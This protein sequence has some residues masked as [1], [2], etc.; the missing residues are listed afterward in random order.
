MRRTLAT[1]TLLGLAIGLSLT[2]CTESQVEDVVDVL[3]D[4]IQVPMRWCAV[5]GSP[6][7]SGRSPGEL[8]SADGI[9]DSMRDTNLSITLP[10]ALVLLVP[11]D[12]PNGIPVVPDPNTEGHGLGDIAVAGLSAELTEVWGSCEQAWANLY[13]EQ[14]GIVAVNANVIIGAGVDTGGAAPSVPKALWVASPIQFTGQR[15]DDL[16]GSPRNITPADVLPMLKVIVYDPELF[17]SAY[18]KESLHPEKVLA[19]EVGHALMLPHG[20]GL[21]DDGDGLLPPDPGER[22]F[23]EYCDAQGENE[24]QPFVSCEETGSLM[25]GNQCRAIRPLQDE[26]LRAVAKLVPGSVFFEEQGPSAGSMV[27]STDPCFADCPLPADLT[28]FKFELT[29]ATDGVHQYLTTVMGPFSASED[30]QYITYLDSDA[31]QLTGCDPQAI[32]LPEF[33]GAD[34]AI[35]VEVSAETQRPAAR[36]WTCRESSFEPINDRRMS[37]SAYTTSA[38]VEGGI[39]TLPMSGTIAVNF[40]STLL[41]RGTDPRVQVFSNRPNV[42]TDSLPSDGAGAPIS[43]VSPERPSCSVTPSQA[44]PGEAMSIAAEGLSPSSVVEITVDVQAVGTTTSDDSGRAVVETVVASDS[45]SGVHLATVRVADQ[46]AMAFCPF[47]IEEPN[48]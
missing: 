35:E 46:P 28:L 12:A 47:L 17:G 1:R 11:A 9:L 15:G 31:D 43:A 5:E 44:E 10:E 18:T 34:V 8:V 7:A 45:P 33:V 4:V 30:T 19:H 29:S 20:N 42:G 37:A 3:N 25:L 16:C 14:T 40:P 22:R 26:L 2:A 13:P 21:D 32:D 24:D 38:I 48:S 36:F 23:D 6:Q 27:A 39:D 41:E